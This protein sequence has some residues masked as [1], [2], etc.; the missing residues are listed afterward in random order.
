M[1]NKHITNLCLGC[2]IIFLLILI[3]N[4][5][6]KEGWFVYQQLP[7]GNYYNG[8]EPKSFYSRPIYRK[9]YMYPVCHRVEYPVP[10]CRTL[11]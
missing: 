4:Q 9:P 6:N 10:H 7:Y 1:K 8:S 11:D 5:N 2:L 3:V